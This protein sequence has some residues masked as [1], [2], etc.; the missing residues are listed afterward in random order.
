MIKPNDVHSTD[1]HHSKNVP[2]GQKE[3]PPSQEGVCTGNEEETHLESLRKPCSIWTL[4]RRHS[5]PLK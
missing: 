1:Y 3:P 2:V 5:K 4:L